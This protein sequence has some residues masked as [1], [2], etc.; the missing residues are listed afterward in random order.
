VGRSAWAL[1]LG[2]GYN[3]LFAYTVV[4][5]NH[6]PVGAAL[7]LVFLDGFAFLLLVAGP[8]RERIIM[9]I[10]LALK[11]AAGAGIGLFIAFIGMVNANMVI[12]LVGV[13]LA[14]GQ[15][16][17][18]NGSA[19]WLLQLSPLNDP[20]VL[21]AIAGL[22]MTG[23]LLAYRVRAALLIGIGATA[24]IAWMVALLAPGMRA[25]LLPT[26]PRNPTGISSF[27]A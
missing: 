8:W 13:P 5:A 17:P 7:A 15:L 6:I 27:I 22:L 20:V 24:L 1:A 23:V 2:L 16:V 26:S 21:V 14:P 11:L 9:G 3:A 12:I 18:S 10:P 19:T 25:A 4:G